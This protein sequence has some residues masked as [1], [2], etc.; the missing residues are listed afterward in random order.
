MVLSRYQHPGEEIGEH[1][2]TGADERKH[3]GTD[4]HE[5]RV[6]AERA[7]YRRADTAQD[8]VVAAPLQAGP[9]W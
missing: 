2:G 7:G 5:Q 8:A 4:P 3:D 1:G 9:S 6:D